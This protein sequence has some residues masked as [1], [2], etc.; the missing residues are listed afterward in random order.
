MNP[1]NVYNSLSYIVY[2]FFSAKIPHLSEYGKQEVSARCK[3]Y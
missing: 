3:R 1:P 2:A